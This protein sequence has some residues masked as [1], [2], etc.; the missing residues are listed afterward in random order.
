MQIYLFRHGETVWNRQRRMQGRLDSPL[1]G[2][3]VD[4][5]RAYGRTLSG[6]L[7]DPHA[8]DLLASPLGRA[9]QSA[10]LLCEGVGRDPDNIVHDPLL[11]E[12]TWGDWDGMT[13]AEIEARDPE[14]WQ[15]RID[16]RFNV[17]PPGGGET[18]ADILRRAA[19]WLESVRHRQRLIAVCHGA[20]GRAIRCAY[21]GEPPERM[22]EMTEPQDA[23]HLLSDG[24]IRQIE[25]S[26]TATG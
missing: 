26:G 11:V 2:R 22:L 17:A 19:R 15:A 16:D 9:W 24:A 14:L 1:T 18:Q 23:F 20:L 3:G 25:C 8:F 12:M 10:V 4:Q 5:A 7:D 6:I 21:L 13:A